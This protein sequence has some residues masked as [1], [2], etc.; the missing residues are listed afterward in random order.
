MVTKNN[1]FDVFK[2]MRK[3]NIQSLKAFGSNNIKRINAG[4]KGWGD[5][6]IAIDTAT[7]I[8]LMSNEPPL[9]MLI[10]VGKDDFNK[11]DGDLSELPNS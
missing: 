1:V 11:V 9:V 2:E 4:K 3:Q 5:V 8:Q 10:V 6:S 7:A